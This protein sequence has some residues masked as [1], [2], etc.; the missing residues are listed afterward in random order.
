MSSS[1]EIQANF[2]VNDT[3]NI[4]YLAIEPSVYYPYLLLNFLGIIIGT[5]G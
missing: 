3:V 2:L 5:T 1:T 4:N